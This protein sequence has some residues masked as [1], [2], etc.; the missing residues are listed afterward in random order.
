MGNRQ[1]RYLIGGVRDQSYLAMAMRNV[2]FIIHA[3][4]LKHVPAAEYNPLEFISTNIIG[5]ENVVQAA[6]Q[7]GVEKVI[8]IRPGEKLHEILITMD[9][10]RD[11]AEIDGGYAIKSSIIFWEVVNQIK[12]LGVPVTEKNF[13]QVTPMRIGSVRQS[14]KP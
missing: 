14:L 3:A 12:K 5:A 10:A 2:N 9:E 1:M 4:A 13:I 8:G 11:A 6:L 7:A